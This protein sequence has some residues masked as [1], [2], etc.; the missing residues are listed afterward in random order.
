MTHQ[1]ELLTGTELHSIENSH[2]PTAE[3]EK[4]KRVG[5]NAE[6]HNKKPLLRTALPVSLLLI[7]DS[8]LQAEG[9]FRSDCLGNRHMHR[10]SEVTHLQLRLDASSLESCRF[11]VCDVTVPG[12]EHLV[13]VVHTSTLAT[14][15][16]WAECQAHPVC[17]NEA[18]ARDNSASSSVRACYA[19]GS[20]H[21]AMMRTMKTT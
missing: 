19:S 15:I 11:D 17:R 12:R 6:D 14:E 2:S 8:F 9:T 1:H 7:I 3:R 18:E 4:H 21:L 5:E 16:G 20:T 13:A 10:L